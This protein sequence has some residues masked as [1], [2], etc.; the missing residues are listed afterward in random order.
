M[1]LLMHFSRMGWKGEEKLQMNP[2]FVPFNRRND[3]DESDGE[4]ER[5]N[6]NQIHKMAKKRRLM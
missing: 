2:I 1:K 6:F 3:E 5:R 4:E